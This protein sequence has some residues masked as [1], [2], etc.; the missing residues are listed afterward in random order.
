[1]YSLICTVSTEQNSISL[2]PK[3][4]NL[5]SKAEDKRQLY[6]KLFSLPGAFNKF[7]HDNNPHC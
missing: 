3:F 6:D 7:P 4:F 2:L 1:M 5:V